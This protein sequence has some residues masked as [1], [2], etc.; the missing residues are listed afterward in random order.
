MQTRFW[1]LGLSVMTLNFTM[2]FPVSHDLV[3]NWVIHGAVDWQSRGFGWGEQKGLGLIITVRGDKL[4]NTD[5]EIS[6]R[7]I[8]V[9]IMKFD[10]KAI[11]HV[12]IT[13][14][15]R[16]CIKKKFFLFIIRK[17]RQ[18]IFDASRK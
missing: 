3:E 17:I 6:K 5:T 11:M 13:I 10:S 4:S 16:V 14:F 15:I 7:G 12:S 18:K 1:T 9:S 8:S 2:T